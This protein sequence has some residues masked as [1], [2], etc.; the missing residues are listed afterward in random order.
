MGWGGRNQ[1]YWLECKLPWLEMILKEQD[2][3]WEVKAVLLGEKTSTLNIACNPT[4][5]G[6]SVCQTC[7]SYRRGWI[8]DQSAKSKIMHLSNLQSH[9]CSHAE[10]CLQEDISLFVYRSLDYLMDPP[11]AIQIYHALEIFPRIPQISETTINLRLW[12]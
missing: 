5:C 2:I 6:I 12:N 1:G 11:V 4:N 3:R 9:W 10:I 7:M 8:L